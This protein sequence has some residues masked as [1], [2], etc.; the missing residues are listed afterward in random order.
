[1]AVCDSRSRDPNYLLHYYGAMTLSSREQRSVQMTR[2]KSIVNW[3]SLL[4]KRQNM[5][6]ADRS[7]FEG[8]HQP[9]VEMA[10]LGQDEARSGD[11]AIRFPTIHSAVALLF[12]LS[13]FGD[14]FLDGTIHP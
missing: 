11:L 8:L 6:I 9:N 5:Y 2:W 7:V 14:L 10:R 12:R 1:M 3:Q 4:F 13:I